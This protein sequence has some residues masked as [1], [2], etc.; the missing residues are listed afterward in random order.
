[1]ARLPVSAFQKIS[2]SYHD[3]RIRL[4]TGQ[5]C[6]AF[7]RQGN[8]WAFSGAFAGRKPVAIPVSREDGFLLKGGEAAAA[9]VLKNTASEIT[10]CFSGFKNAP[11]EARIYYT[12]MAEDVLPRLI[13]SFEGFPQPTVRYRTAAA[14][15]EEH[16]AWVTRGET[17]ADRENKEV[18]IDAGGPFV[19]GHCTA[20]GLQAGYVFQAFVHN[21][22]DKHGRSEQRANTFFRSG[23]GKTG[24]GRAYGYWQL[25]MGAGEPAK[26]ALVLDGSAERFHEV[27]EKY[28]AGAADEMTDFSKTA[29]RFD[30]ALAMRKMP[31]RLSCPE[32]L[33]PGYGWQMTEYYPPH[34]KAAYPYGFDCGMQTGALLLYE[35]MATGRDWEK[36]FGRYVLDKTPL[37]SDTPGKAFFVKTSA[38]ITRWSYFADE[39]NRFPMVEGGNWGISEKLYQSALIDGDTLL[40]QQ[41]LEM[42]MHDVEVKLNLS[43]MYF[44]PCWNAETGGLTDHRDDWFTTCGLAYCAELCSRYLYPATG[45]SGYLKKADR[46]TDWLCSFW[47][48]EIKMNGLHENVNTF[49]CFSAWLVRAMIHRYERCHEKIFLDVAKDLA[50]VMILG[51]CIT[52][53]KDSNGN[54]LLGVTCVGVRGCVDYD[55]TPNLCHEKDQV[56]LDM[57]GLLLEYASG[58]GYA[59][60][61]YMQKLVLPRDG[62]KDAFGIQEQRDVNLRTNYD[63]YARAMTNLSFAIDE[64]DDPQTA[65]FEK[66]VSLRSDSIT[67]KRDLVI[68]NPVRTGKRIRLSIHALRPGEYRVLKNNNPAGMYTSAALSRGIGLELPANSLTAVG[69]QPVRLIKHDAPQIDRYDHSIT[70]LDE[71]KPLDAQRGIG[72]PEPV[73]TKKVT[74]KGDPL[75]INGRT[76]THGLGFKANTVAL[77]QLEGKYKS[78]SLVLGMDDITSGLTYPSPSVYVTLFADGKNIYESGPFTPGTPAKKLSFDVR[79]CKVLAIRVSG[80]WDDGGNISHDF[81]NMADM[82]LTGRLIPGPASPAGYSVGPPP[83]HAGDPERWSRIKTPYG[84][85]I[86]PR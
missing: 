81:I 78:L 82:M 30:A 44:P 67:C 7:T 80:N 21:H 72:L 57:M 1:M 86:K 84:N 37:V 79:R 85:R 71:L 73:F 2:L 53:D 24:D 56:F 62:W 60:Y 68:S 38:G 26:Y 22:I 10:L 11:A 13:V 25:R 3:T 29:A 52:T 32:S 34:A 4:C 61:I 15:K 6:Y 31:L 14:G 55:C 39:V 76:Y 83:G 50:W 54:P 20:G 47:G 41:A 46:L 58:P 49:H 23:Q 12:V 40:K 28:F 48:P 17:A 45:D 59:K 63:N 33:V 51:D 65:V 8:Q 5:T 74:F 19:F 70:Y 16:G 36:N 69:V 66:L 43:K 42:M 27:C 75:R 35:G 64:S 18:F 77:Y 9:T